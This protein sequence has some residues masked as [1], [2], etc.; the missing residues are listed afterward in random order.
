MATLRMAHVY[1]TCG[2]YLPSLFCLQIRDR[3]ISIS[4][5]KPTLINDDDCDVEVLQE[6]DIPDER[7]EIKWYIIEQGR[8][9]VAGKSQMLTRRFIYTF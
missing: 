7:P 5:G 8:I 2:K 1:L 4:L 6:E 3:Q 9:S